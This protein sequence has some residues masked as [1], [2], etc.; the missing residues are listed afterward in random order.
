M[1][2]YLFFIGLMA[3]LVLLIPQAAS[4]QPQWLFWAAKQN[5]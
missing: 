2:K 4:A 5:Q 3:A 1:I